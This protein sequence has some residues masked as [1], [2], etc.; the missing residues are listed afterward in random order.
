MQKLGNLLRKHQ[1]S[2]LLVINSVAVYPGTV[3]NQRIHITVL[4]LKSSLNFLVTIMKCQKFSKSEAL[5]DIWEV[6][7]YAKDRMARLK[8]D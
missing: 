2:Q 3:L 7:R 6:F 1:D 4:L 5:H 8:M